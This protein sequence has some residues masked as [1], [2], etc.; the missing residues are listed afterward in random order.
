[1]QYALDYPLDISR[2]VVLASFA[3]LPHEMSRTVDADLRAWMVE[4]IAGGD[5][6]GYL[7]LSEAT[8]VFDIR[9]RLGETAVPTTA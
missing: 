2:L 8:F 6:A 9:D 1:L 7:S 5:K 4:M 3:G